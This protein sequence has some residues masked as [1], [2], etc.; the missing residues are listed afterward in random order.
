MFSVEF[1]T[2]SMMV[3]FGTLCVI[4]IYLLRLQAS[5]QERASEPE[6]TQRPPS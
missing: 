4:T 3:Q 5:S 6:A 1:V 2:A